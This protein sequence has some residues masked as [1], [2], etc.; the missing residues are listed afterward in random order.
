[1]ARGFRRCRYNLDKSWNSFARSKRDKENRNELDVWRRDYNSRRGGARC[2]HGHGHGVRAT[3]YL[4][5]T[6]MCR[7]DDGRIK[8]Q[9]IYRRISYGKGR[10]YVER[11]A[12]CQNLS[13][14]H[15]VLWCKYSRFPAICIQE[16]TKGCHR[17][18][19]A[20]PFFSSH[21]CSL[22]PTCVTLWCQ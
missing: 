8:K 22:A 9:N 21:S 16:K 3:D 7:N 1:M 15:E 12:N 20:N 10:A 18:T 11:N 2:G 14:S 4:L 19:G 5:E 6:F 17:A 13:R